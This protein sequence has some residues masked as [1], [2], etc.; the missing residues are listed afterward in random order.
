[1]PSDCLQGLSILVVEDMPSIRSLVCR[2]LNTCGCENVSMAADIASAWEALNADVYD[3]VLLDHDLR[4]R[5]TGI[6]LIHM[7]RASD[8]CINQDVPIILLTASNEMLIV[9]DAVRAGCDGYLVKPVPPG[10][11]GRTDYCCTRY[12]CAC[13]K[14]CRRRRLAGQS[15]PGPGL[16]IFHWLCVGTSYANARP[17]GAGRALM[18]RAPQ[19]YCP[20]V[21]RPPSRRLW[22]PYSTGRPARSAS[23]ADW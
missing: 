17:A 2:L 13:R 20:K 14:E 8:A 1:M 3:I 12:P 15:A 7:V 16:L 19:G 22:L 9:T 21:R 10:R 5:R 6:D 4:C 18:A 23:S 11:H